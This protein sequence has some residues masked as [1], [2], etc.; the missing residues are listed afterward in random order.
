MAYFPVHDNSPAAWTARAIWPS[1]GRHL[2]DL[3]PDRQGLTGEKPH[4]EALVTALNDCG[5]LDCIRARFKA[6]VDEGNVRPD[7][8]KRIVLYDSP[9]LYA[10]GNT[11]GS[12]GYFYLGCWIKPLQE[13]V[14]RVWEWSE[15][16]AIWLRPEDDPVK[17][18]D[19]V[20]ITRGGFATRAQVLGY[21]DEFTGTREWPG[22]RGWV[23]YAAARL[24]DPAEW[25]TE[26]TERRGKGSI[27][28]L[29]ANDYKQAGRP[30]SASTD[31][32]T[33][34]EGPQHDQV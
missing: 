28:Y 23:R 15:D 5:I 22:N 24:L 11:N 30:A 21:A 31:S 1:S 20:S 19:E 3:L 17:V 7:E 34:S 27:A 18:G 12:H 32:A 13:K 33:S 29:A 25:W 26:Q 4:R 8:A 16:H 6:A 9:W 14:S 2:L 10:E